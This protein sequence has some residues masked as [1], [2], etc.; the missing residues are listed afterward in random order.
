M[1]DA[2]PLGQLLVTS[3]LL[4]QQALDE[5]LT[6][7]KTDSR[8][9]GELLAD[10]GLVRPQQLAQFLSHQLACPWV[11]LQRVEVTREA[12]NVLPREI[13][14]RHHMVPIHL[15]TSKGATALYVAMDDPTDELALSEA[16]RGARMPVKPMV[17]LASEVRS[18]LDRLYNGG[19]VTFPLGLDSVGPPASPSGSPA[20]PP[21]VVRSIPSPP[22]PAVSVRPPKPPKPATASSPSSPSSPRAAEEPSDE[23]LDDDVIPDS[24]PVTTSKP[25][26][27]SYAKGDLVDGRYELV[28]D[29][30]GRLAGSRWEALH[31]RTARRCVLKIGVR[32]DDGESDADAVRREHL[33]LRRFHHPGAIDL[34]DAGSTDVG[35]PFL[36]VELLEGRSL[37]GLGASRGA[38]HPNE[39]CALVR[40]LGEV[41]VAAHEAGVLHHEVR[42][43]NVLVVRDAYGLERVKLVSWE[44]STATDAP[45]EAAVD[46]AGL[47]A[48][49]F[50]ALVGRARLDGE[51]VTQLS[52]PP[53]LASVVA[54]AIGGASAERFASVREFIEALEAAAPKERDSLELLRARP[55]QRSVVDP[56]ELAESK[57]GAPSEQRRSP[58]APYRTPVRVAAP[59]L[60]ALDGRTEDISERGLLVV[61]RNRIPD[62]TNVTVRFALPIDGRI[63]SEEAVVRWSREGS[64][65]RV[66]GLE[67]LS[68][69]PEATRQ[70]TRYV[71]FMAVK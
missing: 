53:P 54:R 58:R 16:S 28:R 31:V 35:D 34:R 57:P 29:L 41:L 50:L 23:L 14:L 32:S 8:R 33:A 44:Q 67:L 10:K 21:V 39:A 62:G 12:A 20:P 11:S 27:R 47:G 51:D 22:A 2:H 64:D 15:R 46:L 49:T 7:Q 36:V 40:Q 48:C 17:A 43:E 55:E 37:E 71:S 24:M 56:T 45:P 68:P 3:G 66:I 70:I 52:L 13:A 38:L 42:P 9:L 69:A 5:I 63:V 4:T 25:T 18:L 60:S 59:G 1:L 19:E 61:A 65:T 6:L 30:G 26:K